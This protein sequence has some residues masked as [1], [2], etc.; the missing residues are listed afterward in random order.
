MK[1]DIFVLYI[2]SRLS[3]IRENMYIVKILVIVPHRGKNI[4]NAN[5]NLREIANFRECA[6]ISTFTVCSKPLQNVALCLTKESEGSFSVF[7]LGG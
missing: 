1:V 7:S 3:N 6:K 5:I 4:K 2:F